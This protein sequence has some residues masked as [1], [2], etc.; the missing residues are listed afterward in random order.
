MDVLDFFIAVSRWVIGDV[1]TAKV[2]GSDILK[3][4]EAPLRLLP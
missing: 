4:P 1:S 3:R 2:E